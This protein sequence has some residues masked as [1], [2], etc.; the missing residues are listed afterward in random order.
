MTANAET[1]ATSL[2]TSTRIAHREARYADAEAICHQVLGLNELADGEKDE[3]YRVY[4]GVLE[5]LLRFDDGLAQATIWLE[6]T[7]RPNGRVDALLWQARML[8]RKGEPATALQLI[9]EATHLAT[10]HNYAR[11]LATANRYQADVLWARGD[12]EQ[13]LTLLKQALATYEKLR[14][15]EGQ[16][17]TLISVGIT[18]YLMGRWLGAIQST[19][20]AVTL[21]EGS[22]DRARVWIAYNNLGEYYQ[23]IYAM[24][25]ALF[26]HEKAR[27]IHADPPE[28]D[29]LRN[30]GVD[31]VA[32]GRTEEG[33]LQ[34]HQALAVAR[35]NGDR[36]NLLQTLH[37]L[38]D[39]LQQ[40]GNF[41]EARTLALELLRFAEQLESDRHRVRALL[42]LGHC[43]AAE[44]DQKAAQHFF[45]DGFVIA[46]RT[47]DKSMIWQTH[48]ALADMLTVTKP[49]LAAVHRTIAGDMLNSIA[50]SIEDR[51]LR[52]TFKKAPPIA[53]VLLA[54]SQRD[55]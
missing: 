31:L 8:D 53:R 54:S 48:A 55:E 35:Q 46:Q 44:G 3:I 45:Q 29:L 24:E 50:L 13:A 18:Y 26:F 32:L 12:S 9:A 25:K 20:R 4:L 49:A 37:S 38:A 7:R 14:D 28:S 15:L 16:I 19:L 23:Q 10:A 41:A 21:C 40:T 51:E 27:G 5:D 17:L 22:G 30:I 43:A 39:A 2:L 6:Q 47:A 52:E 42:I 11:G 36:D 34:L 33:L 1:T